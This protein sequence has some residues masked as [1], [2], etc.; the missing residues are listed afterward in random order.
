MTA[1]EAKKQ[2]IQRA[3]RQVRNTNVT[4]SH[5]QKPKTTAKPR[6]GAPRQ[7]EESLASIEEEIKLGLKNGMWIH[8]EGAA[9][10]ARRGQ[11][12]IAKGECKKTPTWDATV[13]AALEAAR[14]FDEDEVFQRWK[15]EYQ[16]RKP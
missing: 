7:P 15:K 8:V 11:A 16:A 13:K 4:I 12:M 2:A 3:L 1:E 9:R 14:K 10:E 6:A 5:P